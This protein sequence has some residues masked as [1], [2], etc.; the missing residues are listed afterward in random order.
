MERLQ[1][2][3][4]NSGY[5][6]R[7]KAE[8]LIINGKV[9]VNGKKIYEKQKEEDKVFNFFDA[10]KEMN[11]Y[12]LFDMSAWAKIYHRKLFDQIRF[13]IGKL[14]EDYFVMYKIIELAQEVGYVSEP[15]YNYFQRENSISRNKKIN[16]DFI[17]AA[18]AQMEYLQEKYPK[19]KSTVHIAFASANLTVLDFY[20]KSKVKCPK[21][22]IS[23]FKKA[24]RENISFI[25]KEK[26]ISRKKRLQFELFLKSYPLYYL[27]FSL[28]RKIRRV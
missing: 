12:N 15:L 7:R 23:E 10:I 9:I 1:K 8:E 18:K 3:I 26:S 22:K 17:E 11:S 13:P 25:R 28:Y 16:H 14:S 6:S 19:L 21:S 27:I 5:T 4:A 2:V 20:I 24:V